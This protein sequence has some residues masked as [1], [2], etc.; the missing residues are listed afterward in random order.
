PDPGGL[1]TWVTA[2]RCGTP[3]EEVQ[4]SILASEEYLCAHGHCENGYINGLFI[5]MLDRRPVEHELRHWTHRLRELGCRK[6]L[7]PGL[8]AAVR[9][10]LGCRPAPVAVAA[11]PTHHHPVAPVT[12][13]RPVV[14][15]VVAVVPAAPAYTHGIDVGVHYRGR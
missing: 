10:K 15:P 14:R 1:Q 13:T 7:A 2:L 8:F 6:R 3:A 4:P 11:R 5:D 12:V 9:P